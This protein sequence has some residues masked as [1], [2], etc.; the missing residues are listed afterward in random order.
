MQPSSKIEFQICIRFLKRFLVCHYMNYFKLTKYDKSRRVT[1]DGITRLQNSPLRGLIWFEI[2]RRIF[3]TG[4]LAVD[5]T[6]LEIEEVNFMSKSIANDRN[7]IVD[8][9]KLSIDLT[10]IE[11][12]RVLTRQPMAFSNFSLSNFSSTLAR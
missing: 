8:Y 11:K 9:L 3:Q 10:V 7:F 2:L 4:Y 6:L 12:N 1:N 5:R